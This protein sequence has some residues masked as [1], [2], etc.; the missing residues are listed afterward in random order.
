M[1]GDSSS[2]GLLDSAA[3]LVAGTNTCTRR[4][5]RMSR[6]TVATSTSSADCGHSHRADTARTR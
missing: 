1:M 3:D 4:L 6:T 2:V 5:E